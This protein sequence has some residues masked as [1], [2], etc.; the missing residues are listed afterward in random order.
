MAQDEPEFQ[1]AVDDAFALYGERRFDE[2][3]RLVVESDPPPSRTALRTL[4]EA[5]LYSVTGEREQAL[6]TLEEGIERGE[7]WQPQPLLADPDF[8]PIR[9]DPRFQAVVAESGRR[10]AGATPTS[11]SA[12]RLLEPDVP[13]GS[14]L[15][16]LHGGSGNSN[17]YAT[18][19]GAAVAAGW[20]VVVPQSPLPAYSG[21]ESFNWPEPGV[22]AEQLAGHLEDVRASHPFERL[23]LAGT[24][25]GA[26]TALWCAAYAL[27]VPAVGVLA[28][29]GAASLDDVAPVLPDAAGRGLRAWFLTGERDFVRAAVLETRDAFVAAGV[30]CRLTDVPGVGH[31]FPPDFDDRLPSMLDFLAAD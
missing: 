12:P 22:V 7:W 31:T 28:V 16:A 18:H 24:S 14:A 4:L 1:R 25:Q 30:E 5:G 23:V 10:A 26:R 11:V 19:W 29:A 9:G 2:A 27:P 15:I 20:L 17:E 3:L 8:D 6:R 21:G 13:N